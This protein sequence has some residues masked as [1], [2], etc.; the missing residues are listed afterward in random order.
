M[1]AVTI[2]GSATCAADDSTDVTTMKTRCRRYGRRYGQTR[3]RARLRHPSAASL[4]HAGPAPER[5]RDFAP[6]G[7]RQLRVRMELGGE[8]SA[9]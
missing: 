5:P 9:G 3:N 6:Y 7:A 8:P 4:D 2:S 1:T